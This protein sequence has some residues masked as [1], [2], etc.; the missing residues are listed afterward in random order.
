MALG[1]FRV[2]VSLA[3]R[4]RF[5]LVAGP[6]ALCTGDFFIWATPNCGNPQKAQRYPLEWAAALR[7]MSRLNAE[8]LLPGHGPPMYG[9]PCVWCAR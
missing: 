9:L 1:G 6:I 3:K 2:R 7:K 8:L 4:I 5:V